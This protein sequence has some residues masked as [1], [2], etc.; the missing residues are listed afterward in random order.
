[1]L[2]GEN[3]WDVKG[4]RKPLMTADQVREVASA[5]MEIA[6]HGLRHVSLVSATD[7]ELAAEAGE[8]RQIL[9][10]VSGQG[11]DGFC[12]PYGHIDGRV[13]DRVRTAGYAYGCAI[14]RSDSPAITRCH[15]PSSGNPIPARGCGPRERGTG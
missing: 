9:R 14:W 1:M 10:E 12:Y 13:M 5:G 11:V 8:S 2:G 7:E 15:V 3:S 6:S 4:P